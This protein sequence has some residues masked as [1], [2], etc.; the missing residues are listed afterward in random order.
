MSSLTSSCTIVMCRVGGLMGLVFVN[1]ESYAWDCPATG[2]L[3]P[4]GAVVHPSKKTFHG[5]L[6][7]RTNRLRTR[8]F[9]CRVAGRHRIKKVLSDFAGWLAENV[10]AKPVFVRD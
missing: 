10:E 8:L 7:S 6:W 9:W 4:F 3:T 2:Q 5:V 1:C